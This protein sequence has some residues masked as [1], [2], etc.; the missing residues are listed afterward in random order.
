MGSATKTEK[1]ISVVLEAV[2]LAA[3]IML[4]RGYVWPTLSSVEVATLQAKLDPTLFTRDFVVQ[5]SLQFTPRFYFNAL[6]LLLARAGLPLAAAFAAWHFVAVAGIATGLRAVARALGLGAVAT[7]AW[8][9]GMLTVTA[10]TLGDVYFYTHA[11]VPAVWAGAAVAWGAACALRGRWRTAFALLGVAALLQF[12]VGFYAGLLALPAWFF[13]AKGRDPVGP[14]LWALGLALIYVPM[15]LGGGTGSGALTGAEFVTIYAQL[16]HPH[17]LV[18]STWNWAF[19]VQ[20]GLF[21]GGAWWYLRRHPAGRPAGERFVLN[22]TLVLVAAG[23]AANWLFVEILPMAWMAALQPARITPLAQGIVLALLACRVQHRAALRDWAGAAL[24]GLIPLSPFPGFLLL[25]AAAL[26]LPAGKRWSLAHAVLAL[27]VL[28]AFQPF[29]PSSAAR[30]LRYGLWLALFAALAGTSWLAL[31]PARLAVASALALAA[32]GTAARASLSPQWSDF[33]LDRF[34]VA[35]RPNEPAGRLGARFRSQAPVDALVLTPP[36][37]N[38]WL[39]RLHAQRAA[40]VED[41]DFPF[42]E[43]GMVTWQDR[44]NRVLGTKITPGLD[45]DAAWAA[46]SPAD[47]AAAAKEFGAGYLLTRDAWHP[48]LPGTAVDREQGWTLWQLR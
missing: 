9:V 11:P 14:A 44:M 42:T 35:A 21:H 27:A 6:I 39:F 7:A 16:R 45:L 30:G 33:L 34:A 47:L 15:R 41:K 38:A 28:L 31:K 8:I 19:W 29:D 40:V 26:P 36:S 24:L 12:L 32:L 20:A 1:T 17:H 2:F 10:G 37:G 43:R 46:S 3:V 18:P 22:T 23:L 5:E 25:V 13:R 4:L 48:Q